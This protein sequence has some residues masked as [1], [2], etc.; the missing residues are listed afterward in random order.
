VKIRT[1]RGIRVPSAHEGCSKR[2]GFGRLALR[3]KADL[4][5]PF[6]TFSIVLRRCSGVMLAHLNFASL[7]A[8]MFFGPFFF[9]GPQR[10]RAAARIRSLRFFF[11][12]FAQRLSAPRRPPS[13]CA[14]LTCFFFSKPQV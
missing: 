12:T 10:A 13:L 8:A 5:R 3:F 14:R 7:E 11:D 1:Q 4:S 9:L 6:Q 2:Y